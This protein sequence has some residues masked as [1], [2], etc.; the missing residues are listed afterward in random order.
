MARKLNYPNQQEVVLAPGEM[1]LMISDFEELRQSTLPKSDEELENRIEAFFRWCMEH[2]R[3]P[4]VE[5]LALACGCDRRT[6]WEWGKRDDRRGRAVRTAKQVIIAL[7]EQWGSTGKINP[8]ALIFTLKNI[9]GWKDQVDIA[10]VP[11]HTP[12]P[13]MTPEQIARRIEQDIP[14]DAE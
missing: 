9:A 10:A 3:R 6:L 12:T 7:V 5:L 1:G 11:M 8:A 14:I 2:D 4:G 13:S